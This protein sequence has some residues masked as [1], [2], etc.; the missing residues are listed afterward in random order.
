MKIAAG[1]TSL[2]FLT[3][4]GACSDDADSPAPVQ[5][6]V[7]E[8]VPV[9]EDT[10]GTEDTSSAEDVSAEEDTATG[11]DVVEDT[12]VDE[13]SDVSGSEECEDALCE[14]CDM[15]GAPFGG[16]SGTA[17][18]PWLLCTAAQLAGVGTSADYRDGSFVL[19]RD[20]DMRDL[21]DDAFVMIG[22]FHMNTRFIGAFD[23]NGKEVRHLKINEPESDYIGLFGYIAEG[24]SVK[25]L[26]VVDVDIVGRELVGGLVAITHGTIENVT[27]SG[28]VSSTNHGRA[29]GLAGHNLGT[30]SAS[31]SSVDVASERHDVGGL[32]G[33]N[34]GAI[35]GSS[36]TGSV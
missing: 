32:V 23:G 15:E 16:G 22:G 33:Q 5:V 6:V 28:K 2:V 4:L 19:A 26:I 31:H 7:D 9:D 30:I 17:G 29:G 24:G 35:T 10:S 3:T 20:V 25:D 1:C 21:E 12:A 8:D 27:V 14:A 11:E 18:D 36:S 13:D 34:D